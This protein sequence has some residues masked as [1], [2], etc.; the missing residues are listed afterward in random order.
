MWEVVLALGPTTL[1][2]IYIFGWRALTIILT[3]T[4][5]AILTEAAIQKFCKK[6]VAVADGSAAL[7]GLLLALN[8]PPG[9]PLWLA[10]IGG[11]MAI[12]LGKQVFGGL[13]NNPFNPALVGRVVLLISWPNLMTTWPKPT[14]GLF[15]SV[16]VVTGATPLGLLKEGAAVAT[17]QVSLWDAF[18][19]N[20]G[21][22]IG[23]VSA[24][25]LL[26]GAIF[27]FW[28]KHIS[29][30]IPIPFIATVVLV[31]GIFWLLNPAKYV[32]PLFHLLTGGLILGAFFMATDMVTSPVTRKGQIIFAVGCGLITVAIRLFSK[33][34]EGVS[35]AILMMNG[36]TPLI[37][38]WTRLRKFGEV[39]VNA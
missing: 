21:G 12:G 15:R 39:S 5:T 29:W 11:A 27:L 4:A 6:K 30:H 2:G 37:D 35:F 26:I 7:T 3:S 38:R 25:A 8:L 23:E 18:W 14:P 13:G 16:D 28:R 24:L 31:S 20:I 1:L 10:G 33:S 17:S 9:V 34:P 19:G 36:A 22:C 32:H